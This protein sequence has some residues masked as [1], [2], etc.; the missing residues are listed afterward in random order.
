M[1]PWITKSRALSEAADECKLHN[2]VGI[3]ALSDAT[4]AVVTETRNDNYVLELDYP[5]KGP[6]YSAL[7]IGAIIAA[8]GNQIDGLQPFRIEQIRCDSNKIAHVIARHSILAD[9][10]HCSFAQFT[11]TGAASAF[12]GLNSRMCGK[13]AIK[14]ATSGINNDGI[15]RTI[16]NKYE[17]TINALREIVDTYG[18]ELGCNGKTITLYASRGKDR[19]A[20]VVYGSNMISGTF[21]WS[22][23]SA[24]GKIIPYYYDQ[25]IWRDGS[26]ITTDMTDV[27]FNTYIEAIDV[28]D[29]IDTTGGANPTEDDVTAAGR[30]WLAN[31]PGYGLASVNC[32]VSFVPSLQAE[33][34][35]LCDTVTV[36]HNGLG[37]SVSS[38]VSKTVWNVLLD[39]YDS[40]EI[41]TPSETPAKIINKVKTAPVEYIN[42]TPA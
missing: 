17:P 33:K 30:L 21:T 29:Y 34:I 22:A 2:S 37:V 10:A 41:G 40:V 11:A 13:P 3:A 1:T 39:R 35:G 32:N 6:M 7:Q 38:I 23:S 25:K 16:G 4:S 14:C 8:T 18:G 12:G 36:I 5:V 27:P 26:L 24:Q 28:T 15:N 42:V 19:G 31:H 9:M 20:R